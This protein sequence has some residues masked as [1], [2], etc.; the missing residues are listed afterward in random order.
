M[1]SIVSLKINPAQVLRQCLTIPSL[2]ESMRTAP[3]QTLPHRANRI[4]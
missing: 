1:T 2:S 3:Q 4:V